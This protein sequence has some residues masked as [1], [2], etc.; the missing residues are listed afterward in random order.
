MITN[1]DI[2]DM[3]RSIWIIRDELKKLDTQALRRGQLALIYIA[4]D[5]LHVTS[6]ALE[7]IMYTT[8][9]KEED[10]RSK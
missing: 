8:L 3:L 5:G 7:E 10:E 2:G 4:R 6:L 9:P 1:N